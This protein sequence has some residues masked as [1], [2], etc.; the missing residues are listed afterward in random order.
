MKGL[1]VVDEFHDV[2]STGENIGRVTTVKAT[3]DLIGPLPPAQ[4]NRPVGPA[5]RAIIDE[6]IDQLISWDVVEKSISPTASPVVLVWQTD[7]WRFCVDFRALNAVTKGDAYP[8]LRS[9]YVFAALADKKYFSLM[10]AIKGYHQLE[11]D[12]KD[13]HKTAFI[14]HRGLYQYK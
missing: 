8:M 1:L 5:K 6:T 13:R 4:P 11:I 2:F 9:D 12:E 10:D 14:S 7:K 3:I